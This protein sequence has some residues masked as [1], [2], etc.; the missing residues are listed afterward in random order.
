MSKKFWIWLTFVLL[1]MNVVQLAALY[2]AV[3]K[4]EGYCAENNRLKNDLS[5]LRHQTNQ[6]PHAK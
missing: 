1:A 5:F 4:L 2:N 6:P 3:S